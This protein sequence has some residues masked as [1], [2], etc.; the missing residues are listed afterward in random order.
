MTQPDG[1][2]LCCSSRFYGAAQVL[3]DAIRDHG[4][5]VHH[6]DYAFN[7]W[8]VTV[9]EEEKVQLTRRFLNL[10]RQASALCVFAP[11]G[12]IGRSVC[13]EIGYA[14]ALGRPIIL[15]HEEIRTF[16]PAV[17]ALAVDT[18]LPTHLIRSGW[19]CT[20]HPIGTFE[21][22]NDDSTGA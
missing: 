22:P 13:I 9:T 16:E 11:T 20:R 7:S 1:I 14:F 8:H 5:T 21:R 19:C 4:F 15:S 2:A 17:A 10:I 18:I 12:Y 3:T 6:P